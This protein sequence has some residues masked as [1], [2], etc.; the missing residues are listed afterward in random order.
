MLR[1]ILLTPQQPLGRHAAAQCI[2]IQYFVLK[3]VGA[4]LLLFGLWHEAGTEYRA[5]V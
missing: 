3:V 5:G 1:E 4:I 2:N